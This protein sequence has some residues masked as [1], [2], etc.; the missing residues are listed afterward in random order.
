MFASMNLFSTS[1]SAPRQFYINSGT[2]EATTIT[3][4]S[5]HQSSDYLLTF[6]FRDGSTTLPTVP[7]GWTLIKSQTGAT[8]SGVL[9]YKVAASS[10]ETSGTWTNA[11]GLVCHVYRNIGSI[12]TCVSTGPTASAT[13]NYPADTLSNPFGSSYVVGFAG[14]RSVN[15]SLATP[16]TGM[17]NR[18]VQEGATNDL[19]GHDSNGGLSSWS[20][21][22]V[23]TAET[24]S[25]YVT[26]VVEIIPSGVSFVKFDAAILAASALTWTHT[27]TAGADVFVD[28]ISDRGGT[29][30][31]VTYGGTAMTQLFS[32]NLGSPNGTAATFS[33]WHLASI[34][35]GGQTVSVSNPG[36]T[37]FS[38]GSTSYL[39]VGSVSST[40]STGVTTSSSPSQSATCTPG[41]MILQGFGAFST[42]SG[43]TV[44]SP[45]GG[46]NRYAGGNTIVQM[47]AS[48]NSTSVTFGATLNGSFAWDGLATVLL[49]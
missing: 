37:W 22:N 26:F 32:A 11:T 49:P 4:P 38:G 45:T 20:S 21:T 23:S 9:A 40:T 42:S 5:G 8:C 10:S 36:Y 34:P 2:A 35:G 48:D 44:S 18:C 31:G 3:I 25:G 13:V 43:V 28:F 24:S 27:G 19:A 29:S 46:T 39:H 30:P 15:G 33:R 12:G 47:E 17:V 1:T 6:A 7:A 16:P 14:H 41:Q